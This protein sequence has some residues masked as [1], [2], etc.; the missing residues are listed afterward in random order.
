MTDV[1]ISSVINEMMSPENLA[2]IGYSGGESSGGSGSG[3]SVSSLT[4][5]EIE[6]IVSSIADPTQKETVSFA[7]S[8]VGYPYSQAYRDTGNYYDCSSLA[9]YSKEF[10]FTDSAITLH[11]IMIYLCSYNFSGS[12]P[13]QWTKWSNFG[14]N[15]LCIII[16]YSVT[17]SSWKSSENSF[18]NLFSNLLYLL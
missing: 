1:L 4:N 7:L 14:L 12:N 17:F 6:A 3:N 11:I 16:N 9:Y 10:N 15:A 2:M 8:K 18:F 13:N 5:T